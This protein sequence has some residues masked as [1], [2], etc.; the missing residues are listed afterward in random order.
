MQYFFSIYMD[1]ER[2]YWICPDKP[3]SGFEVQDWICTLNLF[4]NL[5]EEV[6]LGSFFASFN[7]SINAGSLNPLEKVSNDI[8]L[9]LI[10]EAITR[11]AVWRRSWS[12]EQ[13][14]DEYM[15]KNFQ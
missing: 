6:D 10:L 12:K 13:R 11:E 14:W 7:W 9:H 1:F 8:G 4:T 15:I 3:A 2:R 5:I